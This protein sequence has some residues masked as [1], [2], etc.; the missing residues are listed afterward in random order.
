MH[1]K[2][3]RPISDFIGS[4]EIP[5]CRPADTALRAVEVM[6]ELNSHCVYVES[7]GALV[8]VFTERDL[9]RRVLAEGR[10]TA[11]TK[12]EDVMTR[13]PETLR[14]RDDIAYA[15]NMMALGGYR[16]V[17]IV[18]GGKLTGALT[19]RDVVSHLAVVFAANPDDGSEDPDWVDIG[20]G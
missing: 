20:G 1:T 13:T 14:S 2:L 8:G 5:R 6:R 17:P 12:L 10:P 3:H 15:I 19:V 9:I 11:S 7:E 16:N 4:R 18:D